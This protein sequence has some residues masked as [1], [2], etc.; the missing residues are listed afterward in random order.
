MSDSSVHVIPKQTKYVHNLKWLLTA[1]K[2]GCIICLK[3]DF[4]GEA[5]N[6]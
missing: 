1:I 3:D 6:A 4:K 2:M 5:C